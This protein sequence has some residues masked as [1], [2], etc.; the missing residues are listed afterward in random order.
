MPV[1]LTEWKRRIAEL[2]S[3]G[4]MAVL[5]GGGTFLT[6]SGPSELPETIRIAAFNIQVFGKT[7]AADD[8]IMDVLVQTAVEFDIVAVQEIRDATEGTADRFLDELN[9]ASSL[10]YRMVEGPRLGRSNSKEQYAV[11]YRPAVV[12]L[13][14]EFTLPDPN[15]VFEREPLVAAFRA[16]TFDFRLAVAHIK[17]D[18]AVD[19]L[20]ALAQAASALVDSSE[21][22]LILLGDFNADCDY[23]PVDEDHLLRRA[24]FRWVI[25]DSVETAIRSGCTY[26]RIVLSTGVSDDEYVDGSAR[27]FRFDEELGLAD[28]AFV[29]R[30]S[31]HYPVFAEFRIRR[32]DDDGVP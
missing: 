1:S 12:E 8:D 21:E 23:F 13:I 32:T 26:D 20:T 18:D 31:D 2:L 30:V 27:A 29:L 28:E 6:D 16:G 7:K 5:I 11:Y 9:R 15:D 4:T 22:D 25:A 3:V 14:Q 19:E 24:P 17:P 10:P